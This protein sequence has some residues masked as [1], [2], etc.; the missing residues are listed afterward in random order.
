METGRTSFTTDWRAPFQYFLRG[1]ETIEKADEEFL[2][3]M[4]QY[5]LRGM[6]TV[7]VIDEQRNI[8]CFNTSLEVWKQREFDEQSLLIPRFNTSLEVWKLRCDELFVCYILW[9]QY[10]LRGMETLCCSVHDDTTSHRF[11]TSLEVWKQLLLKLQLPTYI[12][13]IL[14]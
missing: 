9:F 6:E 3:K 4:F 5:F 7:D 12:V 13:S 10:F 11:N 1:M 8:P 14:P 2:R